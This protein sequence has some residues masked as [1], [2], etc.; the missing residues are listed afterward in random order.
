MAPYARMLYFGFHA[1]SEADQ[2]RLAIDDIRID[3]SLFAAPKQV[4]ELNAVA[5]ESGELKAKISFRTPEQTVDGK[6]VDA[7]T[8]V[9]IYCNSRLVRTIDAPATG[10]QVEETV[11][12]SE[13]CNDIDV[14][15]YNST[16]RSIVASVKVYTGP[17]APGVARNIAARAVDGQIVISW[18]VPLGKNG[19][20]IDP[21][22]VTY[23]VVRYVDGEGTPIALE[24]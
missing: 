10:T 16:G 22:D 18:D 17:N 9:E 21:A 24:T 15:A 3:G 20:T 4:T 19:G 13:G 2:F 11:E 12:T 14:Y 7:L 8:K 23:S 1:L 5:D 6:Q